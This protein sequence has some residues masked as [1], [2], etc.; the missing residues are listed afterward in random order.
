MEAPKETTILAMTCVFGQKLE[1]TVQY[2]RRYGEQLAPLIV[3]QCAKFIRSRGLLE[4][5]LFRL[6][7]QA[8]LVKELR[9]AFDAGEKPSF[10]SSTDVHTVA[11]LLKLYL[12]E[13]P[14]PLVPFSK[15][16]DFLLCAK[17]LAGGK[18]QS[19]FNKVEPAFLCVFS[20]TDV[21]TVASLLKLYL[22][23]LPEP[24]VP[25]SKYEEF[26]LCA[27]LLAG[28]KEQGLVELKTLLQ[29]LPNANFCL[30]HYICRSVG[31]PQ[32][33]TR[34]TLKPQGV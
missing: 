1:D 9:N 21:H 13:L 10:D 29:Q 27:K 8:T 16:E 11:S 6:P 17:L 3:E 30:L 26:L 25:F 7:G 19:L 32:S 22:R 28:G 14:E 5:G 31:L 12:R 18:E 33:C 20:S 2:E 15:Y 34:T 4:V 23:E 24:L